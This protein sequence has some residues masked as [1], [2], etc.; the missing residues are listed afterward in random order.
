MGF[1]STTL[2]SIL[3]LVA[4]IS[5]QSYFGDTEVLEFVP[6]WDHE[7][8]S[9]SPSSS[10][11]SSPSSSSSSSSS[12]VETVPQVLESIQHSPS[13]IS[14]STSSS[15]PRETAPAPEH[16]FSAS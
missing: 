5:A 6:E 10:S 1:P 15:S 2:L 13:S 3:A 11:S 9:S 8:S 12:Q 4:T 7:S 14:A 16:C